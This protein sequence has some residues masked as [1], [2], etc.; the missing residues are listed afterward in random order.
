[1][2][3]YVTYIPCENQTDLALIFLSDFSYYLILWWYEEITQIWFLWNLCDSFVKICFDLDLLKIC[4]MAPGKYRES[5]YKFEII[6]FPK[7]L[8]GYIFPKFW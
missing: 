8:M 6:G 3:V 2:Y 7:V 1:M 5:D 4:V